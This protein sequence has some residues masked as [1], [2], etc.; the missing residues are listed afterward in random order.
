MRVSCNASVYIDFSK[1]Y[2]DINNKYVSTHFNS[3]FQPR[4]WK[5][6]TCFSEYLIT[7]LRKLETKIK[8]P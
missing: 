8:L 1:D 5:T 6:A 3:N 2:K 7:K 4:K